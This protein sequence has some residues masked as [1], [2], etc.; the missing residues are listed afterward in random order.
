MSTEQIKIAIVGNSGVGKTSIINWYIKNVQETSPTVGANIQDI[1]I[2]IDGKKTNLNIW[3]TAGQLQYRDI[4]P[5]YFRDVNLII[6]CFSAV[7]Q[8]SF[9]DIKSWNDLIVDHAPTEVVKLIVCNKIDLEKD[10]MPQD[11]IDN[12]KYEISATDVFRTS[13]LT[14]E[15][16][17]LIFE[18]I[19][20]DKSIPRDKN[21]LSID[22]NVNIS[23]NPENNSQS[24]C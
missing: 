11:K 10:P 12:M 4:M 22:E 24:C 6:I 9:D 3:D 7:D 16:I 21:F 1:V 13:A 17:D 5:L 20:Y 15:G 2:D 14:G 23:S 18:F 19:K 8:E